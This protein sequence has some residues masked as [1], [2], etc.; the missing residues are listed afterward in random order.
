YFTRGPEW[1]WRG[2]TYTVKHSQSKWSATNSQGDMVA[3]FT[4]HK[5]HLF[6]SS[7]HASLHISPDQD[8]HQRAFI[9]LVILY[10]ENKRQDRQDVRPSYPK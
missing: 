2:H 5:F 9:I 10:S 1:E 3:E 6:S 8:E 4:P 7:E